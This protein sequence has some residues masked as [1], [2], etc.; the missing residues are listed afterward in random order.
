M[1]AALTRF[2]L[3]RSPHSMLAV[4]TLHS[5]ANLRE[6]GLF[7][8]VASQPWSAAL[9]AALLACARLERL[10]LDHIRRDYGDTSPMPLEPALR[11]LPRCT[12]L[13]QIKMVSVC[14]GSEGTQ[15]LCSLS[16]TTQR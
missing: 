10:E 11:M 9:P 15:L 12:W 8:Q 13:R 14:L 6:N 3:G 1:L 7:G 16:R 4:A 5:H 2:K